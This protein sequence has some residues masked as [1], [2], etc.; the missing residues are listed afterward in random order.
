[1]LSGYRIHGHVKTSQ[2][3]HQLT[4]LLLRELFSKN[5]AWEFETFEAKKEDIKEKSYPRTAV[6]NA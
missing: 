1:M 4:N 5:S 2:G 3:G 6:I